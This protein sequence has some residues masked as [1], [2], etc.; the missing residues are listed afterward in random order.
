MY[1]NSYTQGRFSYFITVAETGNITKAAQ[2]LRVSQ[3]SL[4]QYLTRLERDLG[5]RLLDRNTTPIALTEAG[6]IYLEYVRSVLALEKQLKIDLKH[7]KHGKDQTLTLGVPS[8]LIP[9]IFE[10]CIQNFIDQHPNIDV[11]ILEGTS[12]T[13]KKLL[14]DGHVDI[15][16]FHTTER[17]EPLFT[18]RILQEEHLFLATSVD[19]SLLKGKKS[20]DNGKVFQLE[21]SDLPLIN[22]MQLIS[23]GEGYYLHRLMMNYL[24]Q[25]GVTPKNTI[26]V[27]N[28]RAISNYVS[29]VTYNGISILPNF[30]TSLLLDTDNLAYIKPLGVQ[31]PIWYLTMNAPVNQNLSKCAQLFW[32]SVPSKIDLR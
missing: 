8:Q 5:V 23:L 1:S 7:L 12:V 29:N 16:F 21:E 28:I 2:V 6:T 24:R 19:N 27:P 20:L 25:L 26:T 15:A 9:L 18:R 10:S 30:M 17:T 13:T 31:N 3:P 14:L 22:E 4:S 11:K 32:K